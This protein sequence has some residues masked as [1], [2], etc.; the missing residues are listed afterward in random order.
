VAT[1]VDG[2]TKISRMNF[3]THAE[4]QAENLRKMIVAMATDIRVLWSSWPT[5]CTTCAPW[6]SCP[7][8][9]RPLIARKH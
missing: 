7:R 9:S 6:A 3:A 1:I 5:A 4:R 8:P 2:V